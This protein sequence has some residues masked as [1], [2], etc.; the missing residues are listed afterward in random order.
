MIK[1]ELDLNAHN[2]ILYQA[3]L[4]EYY[5]IQSPND[6]KCNGLIV[7]DKLRTYTHTS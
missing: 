5:S 4:K 1:S 7:S 6:T 3:E 2:L